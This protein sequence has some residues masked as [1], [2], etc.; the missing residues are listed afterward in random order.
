[1]TRRYA[2]SNIELLLLT[3]N[4]PMTVVSDSEAIL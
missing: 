3:R 4:I 2:E 1:M